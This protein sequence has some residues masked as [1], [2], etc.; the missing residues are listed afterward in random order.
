MLSLMLPGT[1][2]L[3]EMELPVNFN[4]SLRLDMNT[5]LSIIV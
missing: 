5:V 3:P 2:S 4:L 1:A